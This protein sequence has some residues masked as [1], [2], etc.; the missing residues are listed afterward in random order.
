MVTTPTTGAFTEHTH[1]PFT[2]RLLNLSAPARLPRFG[3]GFSLLVSGAGSGFLSG[4]DGSAFAASSGFAL[5]SG[6][7]RAD[8]GV[9]LSSHHLSWAAGR[10]HVKVSL[11]ILLPW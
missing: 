7:L 3:P 4:G 10:F 8:A 1:L 6:V 2:W 11:S 5:S 9:G